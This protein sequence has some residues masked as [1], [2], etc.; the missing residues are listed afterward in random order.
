[1]R[2]G[3]WASATSDHTTRK[4]AQ[5]GVWLRCY[6]DVRQRLRCCSALTCH[7]RAVRGEGG[8]RGRRQSPGRRCCRSGGRRCRFRRARRRAPR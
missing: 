2:C 5:P 7:G 1:M 3:R 4:P 8:S 6:R